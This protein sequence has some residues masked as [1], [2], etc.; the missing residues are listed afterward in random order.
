VVAVVEQHG[1]D[2]R[3]NA[4]LDHRDVAQTGDV[5]VGRMDDALRY[6]RGGPRPTLVVAIHQLTTGVLIS[7]ADTGPGLD[8][9]QRTQMTHRWAQGAAGIRLGAGAGLGLAIASRYAELM[10]GD[11]RV[12]EGP[13]GLGVRATV[14]L[15]GPLA[16]G[17]WRCDRPGA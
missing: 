8:P 7:V 3:A 1:L 4:L 5:V 14:S 11:L 13:G 10:G 2:W 15:L 17:R 12:E 6:G 16:P 9:K